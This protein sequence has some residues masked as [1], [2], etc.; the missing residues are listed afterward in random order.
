MWIYP[1]ELHNQIYGN[2][3]PKGI[4]YPIE[5][6]TNEYL[7]NGASALILLVSTIIAMVH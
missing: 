7:K 1:A 3:Y 6:Q 2:S 4:K 5:K